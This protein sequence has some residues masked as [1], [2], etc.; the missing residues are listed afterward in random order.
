[1]N[2][3]TAAAPALRVAEAF[4]L[5]DA[6]AERATAAL[7]RY[8]CGYATWGKGPPLVLIH[9]LA[10]RLTSFVPPMALLSRRFRCIA[11]NQPMGREDGAR[12][13]DYTHDQLVADL[14][15]LLDHLDIRGAIVLGHSYGSTIALRALAVAPQR[16]A[17][18]VL[19]CGFARRPLARRE[20]ILAW[21][22]QFLP[23]SLRHIPLR[24]QALEQAHAW[25][26]EQHEPERWPMFLEQ[27]GAVPIAALGRWARELHQTDVSGDLSAVQQPVL[28][29]HGEH[30]VLVR[31]AAQRQLLEGLPNAVL[32]E[33]PGCGHFPMWTHPEVIAGAVEQFA[34]GAACT[35]SGPA[36]ECRLHTLSTRHANCT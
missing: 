36:G 2:A 10:D 25:A 31:T 19:V 33:M 24:R 26:F 27:T 9:G 29:A 1:M 15:E 34:L 12:L 3:A 28:V 21:L 17:R 13:A 18:G 5:F 6:Q 23:G 8:R 30:D 14:F 22:G 20:R 32:F 4:K 35:A 7:S 16:L 11:Y